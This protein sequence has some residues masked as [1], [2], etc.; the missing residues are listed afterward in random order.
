MKSIQL[1]AI[2]LVFICQTIGTS[3]IYAQCTSAGFGLF[4]GGTFNNSNCDG[5]PQV[6]AGNCYA[7]EFSSVQVINGNSYIFSSNLSTD[8]LTATESSSG[9]IITFGTTPI[10]FTATFTGEVFF[11]THTNAACGESGADRTREVA[12]S[13]PVPCLTANY[14]EYPIGNYDVSVCDGI[15]TNEISTT[16]Y[17]GQYTSV[18]L[19]AENSYTFSSST[20][21]DYI[22]ISD[23]SGSIG[24]VAGTTPV[25]FQSTSNQTVRFYTHST[26]LCGEE[27]IDRVR[28]V[29]C[30]VPSGCT[31]GNNYPAPVYTPLICDNTTEN[32]INNDAFAGE[33]TRVNLESGRDYTLTSSVATDQITITNT[34]GSIISDYGATPLVFSPSISGEYR[35]YIHSDVF[36]GTQNTERERRIKCS[37]ALG[38][39]HLNDY[40]LQLHPNPTTSTFTVSANQKIDAISII[41]VEGKELINLNPSAISITIAT[42]ELSSGTYFVRT[43]IDGQILTREIIRE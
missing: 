26:S 36:C 7:G 6:I 29:R 2:G 9:N 30:L 16:C 12:C 19:M 5:I 27:N 13:L 17:A 21:T 32:L 28:A 3:Y 18:N 33:Y 42:E 39:E 14:G 25:E 11:Y 38:I 24:Y 31:T 20:L 34:D 23:V 22:T 8:Y 43:T 1:V 15:T 41:S 40:E 35:F 10:Q 37:S 4:P